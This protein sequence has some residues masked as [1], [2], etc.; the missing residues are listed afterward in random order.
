VHREAD[1]RLA[2]TLFGQFS[3]R[4]E[5]KEV[6]FVRRRDR[7]VLIYLALASGCRVSRAEL[8]NTF[9][10]GLAP[11]VSSQGVRTTLSRLRRAI[12]AAT[13]GDAERY[14]TSG[15]MV[16]LDADNVVVDARRFDD[17]VTHAHE[18]EER[19]E[20]Q[21]ARKHYQ[22][23][24]SLYT[25]SLLRSEPIDATLKPLVEGYAT[26]AQMVS[27]RIDAFRRTPGI[28]ERRS[29]FSHAFP[30]HSTSLG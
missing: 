7:N 3:C 2:I 22:F 24:A 27:Q 28:V 13:G 23:A 1:R 29:G 30:V 9:W 12:S 10:P 19:S 21:K 11:A 6:E 25:G 14:L 18:A 15:N 26:R 20:Y 8:A 16:S 5:D 17:H 4:V